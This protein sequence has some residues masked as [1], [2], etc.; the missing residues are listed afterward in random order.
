[1][2]KRIHRV[3][4]PILGASSWSEIKE[5]AQKGL[6]SWCFEPIPKGRRT[7]CGARECS[8]LIWQA[9]SWSRCRHLQ[10]RKHSS[11]ECGAR[12]TEIDHKIPVALGG[13]GDAFNL[14][15]LCHTCHRKATN[16][17]LKEKQNYIYDSFVNDNG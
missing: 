10:L 9:Q 14:R 1:M 13:T 2:A 8:D 6:C 16:K 11:C 3:T 7:R 12:A 15:S 5:K 4:H 17:F